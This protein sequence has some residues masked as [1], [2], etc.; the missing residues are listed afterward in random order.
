MQAITY[1]GSRLIST[2]ALVTAALLITQY[3]AHASD[4][5]RSVE[6]PGYGEVILDPMLR[7]ELA[8]TDYE[9]W[10]AVGDAGNASVDN[11][12]LDKAAE[13]A[14]EALSGAAKYQHDWNYGNAIHKGNLV[15]GR[16]ALRNND[17]DEAKRRL[18]LA[19]QTPGS[20]QLDSFGPNMILAKE[21]LQ[22]GET[23]AV[24]EYFKLCEK[25]WD[26]DNGSL[27]RWAA[28]VLQG[29]IPDFGP[30]LVY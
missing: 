19:G 17:P 12:L 7:L 25:F 30:N 6:V 10:I 11:N 15:L 28:Q 4:A 16:V 21:L 23:D 20:P 13:F 27:Q 22:V 14:N 2:A 24:L 29:E 8:E 18:K 9:R 3:T 5:P 26:L 1:F